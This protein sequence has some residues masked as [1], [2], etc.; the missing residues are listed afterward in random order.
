[1]DSAV[2]ST[3]PNRTRRRRPFVNSPGLNSS[4]NTSLLDNN[5]DFEERRLRRKSKILTDNILSPGGIQSSPS[6]SVQS[7]KDK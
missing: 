3:P 4:A 7:D 5:N 1:M 2:S 6:R